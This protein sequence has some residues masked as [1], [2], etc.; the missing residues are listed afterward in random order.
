MKRL[1][2]T[3]A[4][5]WFTLASLARAD[6]FSDSQSP[7]HTFTSTACGFY[8]LNAYTDEVRPG[9][10]ALTVWKSRSAMHKGSYVH[11]YI[12]NDVAQSISSADP[13][14]CICIDYVYRDERTIAFG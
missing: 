9:T 6:Y 4:I 11:L 12:A 3:L 5:M 1:M 2:K 13:K 14:R 10:T 8:G 7:G